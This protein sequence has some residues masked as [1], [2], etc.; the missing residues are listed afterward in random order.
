MTQAVAALQFCNAHLFLERDVSAAAD[1]CDLALHVDIA[2]IVDGQAVPGNDHV[3]EFDVASLAVHEFGVFGFQ[4]GN[5]ILLI[6]VA[7]ARLGIVQIFIV[8]RHV[9]ADIF[10]PADR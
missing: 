7:V 9:D 3:I 6:S 5:E 4:L 1:D 2:R 10:L 8:T